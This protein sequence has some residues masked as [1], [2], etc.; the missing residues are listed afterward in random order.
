[1]PLSV[2]RISRISPAS[3]A[4]TTLTAGTR[5]LALEGVVEVDLPR[6][7]SA[8]FRAVTP[9][10]RREALPSRIS[11]SSPL[12]VSRQASGGGTHRDTLSA[13]DGRQLLGL[14]VSAHAIAPRVPTDHV[15]LD[16]QAPY[17]ATAFDGPGGDDLRPWGR[18]EPLRRSGGLR[19]LGGLGS[20]AASWAET[21]GLRRA[22]TCRRSVCAD[23][24]AALCA[25][26]HRA[27]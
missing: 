27:T 6:A 20:L 4:T 11:A 25:V 2:R 3:L 5:P 23:A 24:P 10:R 8:S 9:F 13:L 1:L 14:A 7:L 16:L 12:P 18:D 17:A 19:G 21:A 22:S 15:V 26:E